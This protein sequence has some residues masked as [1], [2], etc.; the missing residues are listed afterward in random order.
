MARV[1]DSIETRKELRQEIRALRDLLS[2]FAAKL[3]TVD[4][5]A[6]RDV[7]NARSDLFAAWSKLREAPLD[8]YEATASSRREANAIADEFQ[9]RF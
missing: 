3:D 2:A 5:A 7:N 8:E 6:A 4:H 9:R 1:I